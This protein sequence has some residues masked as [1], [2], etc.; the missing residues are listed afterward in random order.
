[1]LEIVVIFQPGLIAVM[2]PA[3]LSCLAEIG[4]SWYQ[5]VTTAVVV[6]A[7]MIVGAGVVPALVGVLGDLGIGW[8]GFLSLALFMLLAVVV[9]ILTPSFGRR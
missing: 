1:M 5:N 3:Q 8:C 9:L 2:Y 6:T 4:E 7:G